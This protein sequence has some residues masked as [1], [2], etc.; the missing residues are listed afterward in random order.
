MKEKVKVQDWRGRIIGWIE[1]DTVTGD[2]VARDFYH[3]IVGRYNKKLDVTTD[4]YGRRIAK[5][6]Q[7]SMA[8]NMYGNK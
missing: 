5:G 8:I 7:L 6:D 2:K 3:R 4:F 1:T